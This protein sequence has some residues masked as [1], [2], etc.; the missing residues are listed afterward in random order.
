M[1]RARWTRHLRSMRTQVTCAL[2]K[3]SEGNV[4]RV[5]NWLVDHT[6]LVNAMSKARRTWSFLSLEARSITGQGY[7]MFATPGFEDK[8]DR[9][10]EQARSQELKRQT[11]ARDGWKQRL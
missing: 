9:V 1:K 2:G 10:L 4:E 5:A 3:C 8:V 7:M 6:S 11:R